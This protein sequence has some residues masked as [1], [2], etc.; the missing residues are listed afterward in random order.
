MQSRRRCTLHLLPV[1]V[2]LMSYSL[3]ASAQTATNSTR[4]QLQISALRA[5]IDQDINELSINQSVRQR[6][7]TT[8][9]Q[10][11]QLQS[12]AAELTQEIASLRAKIAALAH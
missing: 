5:Q 9:R 4:T 7:D 8:Q 2:L 11:D 12:R 3:T 1:I 10:K 6:P